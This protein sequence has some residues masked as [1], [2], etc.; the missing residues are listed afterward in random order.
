MSPAVNRRSIALVA[1]FV[2]A[3]A[4]TSS[5]EAA[6]FDNVE[7]WWNSLDCPRKNA[8]V[9]AS[10]DSIMAEGE[11][12][13]YC[14]MYADLGHDEQHIVDHAAEEIEGDYASIHLWWE[15]LDC[16]KMTIAVGSGD[17]CGHFVNA[18]KDNGMNR[19]SAAQEEV[20]AIAGYALARGMTEEFDQI[21]M[22]DLWQPFDLP[23]LD[24]NF[25]M[26]EGWWNGLDCP[27]M[28]AA[29]NEYDPGIMA[30][31]MDSGYCAMYADLRDPEKT[32][33]RE[34]V[35]EIDGDYASIH[36]WWEA[37]DCRQMSIATGYA[38]P[39]YCG[40]FVNAPKANEM[41]TLTEEQEAVVAIAGYALATGMIAKFDEIKMSDLW[42]PFTAV[43]ALPLVGLGIL[44]LLLAGR[45]A[46][47]RRRAVGRHE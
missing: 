8:A 42:Q 13:G 40:H 20:V 9:N 34:A 1:V 5:A 39:A 26:V 47:L 19:L 2:G 44:G 11:D 30:T 46:W 35:M 17:Y 32:V 15:A 25:S 41:N 28:N 38:Q 27:R 22:S 10:D 36:L 18:P 16:R 3:L 45:G 23:A 29:V 4:F 7:G 37:L 6:S 31:G 21:M 33:V 12:S 24:G 43:P 14:A